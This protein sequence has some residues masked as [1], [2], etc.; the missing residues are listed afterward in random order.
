MRK[1]VAG[2]EEGR[3]PLAEASRTLPL[4]GRVLQC[5]K[6]PM[7]HYNMEYMKLYIELHATENV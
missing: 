4:I 3:I 1:T 2:K 5:L 6:W 7:V